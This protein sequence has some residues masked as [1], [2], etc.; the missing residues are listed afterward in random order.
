MG[1]CSKDVFLPSKIR[2]ASEFCFPK[3]VSVQTVQLEDCLSKFSAFNAPP[4]HE[5]RPPR[6][7]RGLKGTVTTAEI[8]QV[9]WSRVRQRANTRAALTTTLSVISL[10]ISLIH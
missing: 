9:V 2:S 4:A 6:A 3:S 7:T 8:R 10:L 1:N 5:H